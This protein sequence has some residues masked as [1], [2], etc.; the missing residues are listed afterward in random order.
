M[1]A[2]LKTMWTMVRGQTAAAGGHAAR[3]EA[4]Y[5]PQADNYDRFREGLLVG[6]DALL[7]QLPVRAGS[8]WVDLGGGTGRNAL[9]L[10]AMGKLDAMASLTLVDLCEPLLSVARQ[11][12]A[13]LPQIRTV[14][15]DATS[16]QPGEPVD[17]VLMSYALTM[18]P[19]WYQAVDNALAMLKPGGLLAVTD[20]YVARRFSDAANGVSHSWFQRNLWPMWFAH[21][22][23]YLS[24]DHLPY[25]QSRTRKTHLTELSSAVPYLAPT[26]WAPLRVPHYVYIGAKA[27]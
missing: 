27:D 15:A 4:F 6:R 14:R 21:D 19:D 11:R 5:A 12:S 24:R 22:G 13:Q 23:V 10:Q 20:F 1:L 3:L 7:K 25:L 26:R 2:D 17:G 16:W 9:K 8:H 18:V